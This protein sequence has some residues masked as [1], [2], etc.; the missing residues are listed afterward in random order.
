MSQPEDVP[1]GSF[2]CRAVSGER[3]RSSPGNAGKEVCRSFRVSRLASHDQVSPRRS[4]TDVSCV[5]RPKG[6]R[7]VSHGLGIGTAT[8]LTRNPGVRRTPMLDLTA[9]WGMLIPGE[10]VSANLS[11][12]ERVCLAPGSLCVT[13]GNQ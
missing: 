8:A 4:V 10:L 9:R 12:P 5:L 7:R 2:F 3:R 6:Q 1:Q 13:G 11:D